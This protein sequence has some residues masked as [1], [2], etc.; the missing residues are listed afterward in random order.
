[1]TINPTV[2]IRDSIKSDALE[3]RILEKIEKLSKFY[4]HIMHCDVVLEVAQKHKHQGKLYNCRISATVPQGECVV[5]HPVNEDAYV[6]VRDAFLAMRR[7]LQS[8][9][10]KQRR[11]T[12]LH[13]VVFHGYVARLYP[14]EGF[15]FIQS[16]GSEYYFTRESVTHPDFDALAPGMPVQFIEFI[17]ANGMQANRVCMNKQGLAAQLV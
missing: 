4:P 5:T 17:S 13:D 12:K 14:D 1:M 11:E 16:N 15:G 10:Q 3:I 9:G 2:T 6:A 8:Y 7:K